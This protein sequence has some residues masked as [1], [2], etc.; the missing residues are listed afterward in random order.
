M[1]YV[2]YIHCSEC[3]CKLIYDGYGSIRENLQ[4]R[5]DIPEEKF[6]QPLICPE[7]LKKIIESN[8][9]RTKNE[10]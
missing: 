7:C 5:Y 4:E 2:D 9:T 10:G 8:C 1:A 3:D 6:N